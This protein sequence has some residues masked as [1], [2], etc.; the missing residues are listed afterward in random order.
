MASDPV[1]RLERLL[2]DERAAILD[3]ALDRLE[4]IAAA[5]AAAAEGIGP[6][7]VATPER[8]ARL[9]A[10][11]EGNRRLLDGAAEGLRAAIRRIEAARRAAAHLDTYTEGGARADLAAPRPTLSRRA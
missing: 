7:P 10:A 3:G 4:G 9:R 1:A 2:E 5:K 6:A 8:L 11:A